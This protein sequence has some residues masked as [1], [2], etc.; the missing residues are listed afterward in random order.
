VLRS[1]PSDTFRDGVMLYRCAVA[2][3][4]PGGSV[5][6]FGSSHVV[7]A[8]FYGLDPN[9]L[10]SIDPLGIGPSRLVSDLFKKYPSPNDTGR[11]GYNIMGY[12]F[13]SPIEN[14]F[15]T[16]I[17]RFD[18]NATSNQKFFGRFNLQDD[19]IL[20]AQQ[21][22]DQPANTTRE[23]ASQGYAA[24]HDWVLGSTKVNTF[25]YGY[26]KIVED[27]IG[28]L[29][30]DAVSFRFIDDYVAL[31]S[32]NGRET[33]THNIVNDFNWVAGAHSL[34]FGTNLRFSRIPRY[35]NVNSYLSGLANGSWVAGVGRRYRPGSSL[36]GTVQA[37]SNALPAVAS[38]FAA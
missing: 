20:D 15:K 24:G 9:A 33:P 8:G 4:C 22:P 14:D 5:N 37:A 19:A 31:T 23:V 3:Q 1:V 25:R 29:D 18:Y 30:A 32:S 12:R 10:K 21:F 7:P 17:G 28:L 34:K 6:G 26:T 11:D 36:C 2:S 13:A 38:G 35:T 27:T 16:Y